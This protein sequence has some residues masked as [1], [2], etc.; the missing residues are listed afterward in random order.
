MS[1]L[2]KNGLIITPTARFKSDVY[3]KGEK[4]SKI[5]K[6]L[7]CNA[8]SVIDAEDKYILPGVIDA[9]VHLKIPIVDPLPQDDFQTGTI[10]AACGGVTTICDFIIQ[11]KGESLVESIRKKMDAAEGKAAID[12]TFHMTITDPRSEVLSEIEKVIKD[13]GITS[14]KLLM[15]Y[16]IKLDDMSLLKVAQST[17]LNGGLILVHAENDDFIKYAS[18]QLDKK[19]LESVSNFNISR[20]EIAEKDAI[21]R[22]INITELA[23]CPLYIVHI[24]SKDGIDVIKSSQEKNKNIFSET[25]PHYL[26]FD[27]SNYGKQQGLKYTVCPPLRDRKSIYALWKG[28][29]NGVIQVVS[30]DHFP[31]DIKIKKKYWNKNDYS[32]IPCGLPGVETLLSLVHTEGVVKKRI[33]VE[34]MVD[35]LCAKPAEIFRL[36]DKGSIQPGKDADIIVFNPKINTRL[37][38]RNLHM[39]IDYSPYEDYKVTGLPQIVYSR[40]KRVSEFLGD[41]MQYTGNMGHGKFVKRK[42]M[43]S[44]Q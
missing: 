27:S 25:C 17:G 31:V 30:T 38:N 11:D 3:V 10:A 19:K 1:V 39:N 14:I 32:S 12:Y 15:T 29:E 40:G 16:K 23:R 35:V 28:I 37:N 26:I 8:D 4:I 41:K 34:K 5:G 7:E 24:S 13:L 22:I 44:K 20:P 42:P 6:K 33:K 21:S 9:H 43:H 18:Q 2:I 36:K